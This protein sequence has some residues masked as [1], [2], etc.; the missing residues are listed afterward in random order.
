MSTISTLIAQARA[1]VTTLRSSIWAIDVRDGIGDS[2]QK[3]SEAI[4]QCYSDVS[5]PTLQTEALEAAL[6]NK[7]D[8]GEMAALT[9]GD[10]TITAAKLA[11]GVID[12]TLA[13]SGAAADAAETGRQFGLIKADLDA[14]SSVVNGALT[15]TISVDLSTATVVTVGISSSDKWSSSGRSVFIKV[16]EN[17]KKISITANDSHTATFAFL[18]A[19]SYSNNTTVSTYCTGQTRTTIGIGETGVYNI[20]DDCTYINIM[21]AW[22]SSGTTTNYKPDAVSL[23]CQKSVP[24]VDETFTIEGA[25]ADSYM[26]G[27]RLTTV[28]SN[29]ES[30]IYTRRDADIAINTYSRWINTSNQWSTSGKCSVLPIPQ[31]AEHIE[32]KAP[33]GNDTYVAFLTS[34]DTT[35]GAS[36][37]YATGTSNKKVSAGQTSRFSIPNDASYLYVSKEYSDVSKAPE[38]I[39]YYIRTDGDAHIPLGLHE[40]PDSDGVINIVKRCRQMTDIEWTPAV[41][42][43]RYMSVQRGA[44][45]I[46][47]TAESETYLGTFRAGRKYKGIPYGRVLSTMDSYGYDYGTV[48]RYIDFETFVS[49]VSNPKSRLCNANIGAVAGHTSVIYASVCSGLTCY[50]LNVPEVA[51]ASIGD[52]SGLVLIGKLNANGVLLDDKKIKIGDVLNKP[53]VH[54]AIVT[55]IIRESNGTIQYIELADA[56]PSGLADRGHSDG[57]VGGV[58]RRKGYSR[59][60]LY[61][62][63]SWGDYYVYRYA[64]ASSVPYTPTPY[65]NVGDEMDDWKIEHFPIMPY[66]G[67]GFAYKTGHIP[68]SHVRLVITLSG[69]EYVKVFKDETEVTGSPFAVTT[70][71][72]DNIN[73]IDV[74]EIG[75]GEYYAYLCNISDGDVVNLSYP[76]HWTVE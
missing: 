25:A 27:V 22:V 52:I 28:E 11:Q 6:Q 51:T 37:S 55:D 36:V 38:T 53:G 58:C 59:S 34:N 19:N 46:P 56:S 4:E 68:D 74:T 31:T 17:A 39:Y 65:V 62:P 8:E 69:Y 14:Q 29:T 12:N 42:L 48:G 30:L 16:P 45:V 15:D 23:V 67:E 33:S 13:T 9:I 57:L 2:I 26:T 61:M 76:C 18:T 70:D 24:S 3:L 32:V 49:S 63:N 20:P 43:P 72:Q 60:H 66:E 44:S 47:E 41:D 54:T 5:N 50:A 21:T 1:F 73:P 64:Y 7:I 71:A 40:M 75:E 10:H 35:N